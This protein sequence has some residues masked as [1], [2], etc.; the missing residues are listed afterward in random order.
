MDSEA[1]VAWTG[2]ICSSDGRLGTSK[3][4]PGSEY[5]HGGHV[6]GAKQ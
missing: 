4:S 1:R 3:R 6:G 2:K 5:V